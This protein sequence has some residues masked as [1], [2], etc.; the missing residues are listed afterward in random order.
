[1]S[2]LWWSNVRYAAKTDIG[3]LR[4]I[5]EDT[6]LVE[7]KIFA[8]AD[9]MGGHRAGEVASSMAIDILKKRAGEFE[10]GD[11][12][13]RIQKMLKE[14]LD[15]VNDAIVKK[16]ETQGDY[17]G[18]GTTLTAFHISERRIFLV[19]IGDSR[20]YLIRK[21]KITQLT[22]DHTLVADMVGKGEI[23][24]EEARI[25]PLKNILVRAL[26]T[27]VKAEADLLSEEVQ[28]GDRILLCSDGLSSMLR[29]EEILSIVNESESLENACQRL[30]DTANTNG[31]EDNITV[32]LVE[33]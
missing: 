25:H 9:G 15:E 32:V 12:P 13:Q 30:I 31:G 26:G 1:M 29:D 28:P 7:D 16:G 11:T 22:Q 5:N 19:H 21:E 23:S 24:E 20:A 6:F 33:F 17:L 27:D 3:K 10:E 4:E 8:V 18:M 14:A 2:A